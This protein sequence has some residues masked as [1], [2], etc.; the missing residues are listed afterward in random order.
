MTP[1]L[2]EI[3]HAVNIGGPG[4][5]IVG[6]AVF[7]ADNGV[8]GV[9]AQSEHLAS[10]W[11]AARNIGDSAEDNALEGVLHSI[12]HHPPNSNFPGN[13]GL[14]VRLDGLTDGEAYKLQLQAYT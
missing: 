10:P 11:G 4:G 1:S 9:E 13:D 2:A 7:T 12:R 3:T 14:H 5:A 8:A 6:D